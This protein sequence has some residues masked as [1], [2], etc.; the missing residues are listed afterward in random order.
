[1]ASADFCPI[2]IPVARY[3]A[4]PVTLGFGGCATAFAVGL[5]PTPIAADTASQADLPG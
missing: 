1:M 3:C 4:V 2:T 5:S